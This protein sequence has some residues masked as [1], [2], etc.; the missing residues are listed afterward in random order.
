MKTTL[1][2]S[3][4][5]PR[6]PRSANESG[7]SPR[8]NA[9]GRTSGATAGAGVLGYLGA[10]LSDQRFGEATRGWGWREPGAARG[11]WSEVRQRRGIGV[12]RAGPPPGVRPQSLMAAAA[13]RDLAQVGADTGLAPR[14]LSP[15]GA[16]PRVRDGEALV[17]AA[18]FLLVSMMGRGEVTGPELES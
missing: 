7:R 9:L 18:A 13:R 11:G 2:E 16:A 1:P 5:A 4:C 3:R 14:K 17:S 8:R 6:R 10:V 12:A 15:E